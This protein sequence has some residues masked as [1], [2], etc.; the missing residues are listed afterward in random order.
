[1]VMN[2]VYP[3]TGLDYW[4]GLLDWTTGLKSFWIRHINGVVQITTLVYVDHAI[5]HMR[6][7]WHTFV[8]AYCCSKVLLLLIGLNWCYCASL[9]PGSVV[10]ELPVSS[11]C[12]QAY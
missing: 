9:R 6:E 4:T 8:K 11:S 10:M 1:M 7:C 2:Q 3:F 12:M 5:I